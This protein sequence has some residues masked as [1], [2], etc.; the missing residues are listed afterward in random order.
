[1]MVL[2]LE[3]K[4]PFYFAVTT[5]AVALFGVQLFLNVGGVIRLI[6]STGVTLSFISYGGSS[7]F[8]SV[9][10][11]QGIQ[12]MR[13]EEEKK[14][15]K[16][17][18]EMKYTGQ[19]IRMIAVCAM[20]L[21][22]LCVMTAYFLTV[23]VK[24]ATENYY[25]E[26]NR[27][28]PATEAGMLKGKILAADGTILARSVRGE[29]GKIYRMYPHQEKTAFVTGQM[30]VGRSGLEKQY[31]QELY[32]VDLPV[33][34]RIKC[35]ISGEEEEGNSIVTTLDIKLQEAAYEALSGYA[36]A[37]GVMEVKTGRMLAL[38]STPSYN[39]NELSVQWEE[40]NSRT[41]APFLNRLTGGL[42]PPGSTFILKLL[43]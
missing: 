10:L 5:G 15:K 25:N 41:D 12:A 2:A 27:R 42:Y 16:E 33:W 40:L 7:L 19:K 18:K 14:T 20:T 6:P 8:S 23:T 3:R 36:G 17:V 39:P 13:G 31:W 24:D 32:S 9:F 43:N 28:I 37:I 34:E 22:L 1:M 4:K 21:L 35:K 29:D 30:M 11:F 38:V 26:Y